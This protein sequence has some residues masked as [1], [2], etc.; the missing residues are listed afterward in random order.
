MTGRR[1]TQIIDRATANTNAAG[2]KETRGLED[3]PPSRQVIDRVAA[4][5][6]QTMVRIRTFLAACVLA[7]AAGGATS[8]TA[9]ADYGSGAQYQIELS[10]N[11]SGKSGG[12]AWLWISLNSD[13]TGDYSGADCGHGGAGAASD[14]GDV[15]WTMSGGSVVI[16]GVVLNGLGGFPTTVTVPAAYGHYTGT[17]GTFLTVPSFIPSFVGTS[18]LQVAP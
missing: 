3:K 18:Q 11:I 8:A 15:T 10:A 9:L 13:G 2:A 6:D 12:G 14:K 1:R 4:R 17:V 7:A 5:R 16:S